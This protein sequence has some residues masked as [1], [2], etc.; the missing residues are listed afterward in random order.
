M[1]RARSR[2][3]YPRPWGIAVP[4]PVIPVPDD[5]DVDNDKSGVGASSAIEGGVVGN[6]G[7]TATTAIEDF[8][9]TTGGGGYS[10]EVVAS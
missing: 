6:D 3:N 2:V 4:E 1:E 9:G 5:V 8:D 10:S 7:S